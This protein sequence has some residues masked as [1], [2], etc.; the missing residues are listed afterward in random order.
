MQKIINKGIKY[1]TKVRIRNIKMYGFDL[2]N[3]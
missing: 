3:I 2:I 1:V